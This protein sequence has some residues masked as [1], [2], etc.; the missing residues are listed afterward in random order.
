MKKILKESKV[1]ERKFGESLPTLDSVQKRYKKINEGPAYEYGKDNNN[2]ERAKLQLDKAMN[3]LAK[4]LKK[5]GH[6]DKAKKLIKQFDYY[7]EE[8]D[9]LLDDILGDL[10]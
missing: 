10:L 1:W 6:S 7:A 9:D 8:C 5:N 3:G 2:I 4:T